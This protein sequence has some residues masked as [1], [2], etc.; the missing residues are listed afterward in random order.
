MKERWKP[1]KGFEGRYEVSDRGR[2]RS[3]PRYY[4][5]KLNYLRPKLEKD[6]Y[7]EVTLCCKDRKRHY[8][9]VHRLVYQAFVGPLDPNLQVNHENGRKNDNRVKN[10]VQMTPK[11]NTQHAIQNKLRNRYGTISKDDVPTILFKIDCGI[12]CRTI[13][14]SY[15]VPPSR[16]YSIKENYAKR[17]EAL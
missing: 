8:L 13:A 4:S 16:I 14:K 5:P 3:L 1:I 6:G 12:D 9:K 15:G 7:L 11:Q 10:L 17:G 2:V